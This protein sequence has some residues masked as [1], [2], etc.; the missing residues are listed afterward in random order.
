MKQFLLISRLGLVVIFL[1][2]IYM[3]FLNKNAVENN[4]Q[5]I[6][7]NTVAPRAIAGIADTRLTLYGG[8][9]AHLDAS[10][11]YDPDGGAIVR[12]RWVVVDTP[13]ADRLGEV[14]Y[15]GP[16]RQSPID[17]NYTADEV[18]TWVYELEV[19]DDEGQTDRH[20]KTVFVQERSDS[21]LVAEKKA[22][23]EVTVLPGSTPVLGV[24]HNNEAVVY[25]APL[26]YPFIIINDV[27]GGDPVY[28]VYCETCQSGIVKIRK[29]GDQILTFIGSGGT[30]EEEKYLVSDKETGSQWNV[31]TGEA[32]SGTLVGEELTDLD[33]NLTTLESWVND[34]P[35]TLIF[36]GDDR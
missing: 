28:I 2:A 25:P 11:S 32:Q 21:V 1:F 30:L 14:L 18:G 5:T 4:N 9:T 35:D 3:F 29:V 12:Y 6:N 26:A 23:H 24:V 36:V 33:F 10:S 22:A 7:N 27:I 19:T 31:I 8:G 13:I 16:V 17:I 20:N 15:D 34:H